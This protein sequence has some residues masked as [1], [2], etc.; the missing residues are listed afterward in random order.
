MMLC[1]MSAKG[2]KVTFNLASMVVFFLYGA[3]YV[4]LTAYDPNVF[5]NSELS[6]MK[7]VGNSYN[8]WT[9]N[10]ILRNLPGGVKEPL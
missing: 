2:L 5:S 6:L 10:W 9:Y 4:Y 1:C 8:D 7:F 3:W